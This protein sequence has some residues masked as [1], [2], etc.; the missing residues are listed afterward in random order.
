MSGVGIKLPARMGNTWPHV[1]EP[2]QVNL[3]YDQQDPY[4]VVIYMSD[5][6]NMTRWVIGRDLLHEGM[7]AIHHPVGA[8]DLTVRVPHQNTQA[9]SLMFKPTTGNPKD[10]PLYVLV[11]RDMV[12]RFLDE[13][14]QLVP[15]GSEGQHMDI[16]QLI[17]MLLA[18]E[19]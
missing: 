17:A 10:E 11:P 8:G 7:Y 2:L 4:G 16:D 14:F 3:L 6:L 9:L 19:S 1:T 15:M 5:G 12:R 18:E 13:T